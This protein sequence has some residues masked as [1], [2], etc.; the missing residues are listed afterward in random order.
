MRTVNKTHNI[1]LREKVYAGRDG[2]EISLC[3]ENRLLE[4]YMQFE[5]VSG[6]DLT[7]TTTIITI[8]AA[9][10]GG[11]KRGNLAMRD[12]HTHAHC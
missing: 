3:S 11:P 10:K 6:R 12:E 9:G 4:K 8:M 1:K 5:I 2:F 7:I